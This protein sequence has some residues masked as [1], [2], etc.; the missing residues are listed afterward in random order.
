MVAVGAKESSTSC[1]LTEIS[2]VCPT[3]VLSGCIPL[4]IPRELSACVGMKLF[5]SL[6]TR[7]LTRLYVAAKDGAYVLVQEMG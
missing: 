2:G 3:S 6:C 7:L 1:K 4:L 5:N